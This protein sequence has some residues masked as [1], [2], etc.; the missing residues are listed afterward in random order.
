ML[1][2]GAHAVPIKQLRAVLQTSMLSDVY[3]KTAWGTVRLTR[4]AALDAMNPALRGQSVEMQ[5]AY[6]A[7]LMRVQVVTVSGSDTLYIMDMA[8]IE[9]PQ[10]EA[11]AEAASA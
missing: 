9:Q 5:N 1:Q 8:P 3:A 4:K 2:A 6:Q 10:P 7:K 11:E